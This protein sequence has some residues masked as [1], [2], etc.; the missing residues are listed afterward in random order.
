MGR[1]HFS[2]FFL[3]KRNA[4]RSKVDT[5][6]TTK[7]NE[8]N[9]AISSTLSRKDEADSAATVVMNQK[10]TIRSFKDSADNLF[11]TLQSLTTGSAAEAQRGLIESL[12]EQAAN[13]LKE[14]EEAR[15]VAE[16][17]ALDAAKFYEGTRSSTTALAYK[18]DADSARDAAIEAVKEAKE[19]KA[20]ID[21]KL[22]LAVEETSDIK[23][24]EFKS[25]AGVSIP[26]RSADP[27]SAAE[28]TLYY[29]TGDDKLY[30]KTGDG[31]GSVGGGPSLGNNS[32][33]RTNS[34]N[35]QSNIT[36]DSNTNAMSVGPITVDSGYT[37]TVNG[38]WNVV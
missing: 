29:H 20:E 36:V 32:I 30:L 7:T 1:R 5:Y 14:A 23:L 24:A 19:L 31:F 17:K 6:V 12:A 28:G 11:T 13:A 10:A 21:R 35:I 4:L 34:K 18:N 16:S 22:T 9:T 2:S 8:R 3:T 37:V 33:I 15:L 25:D 38:R 27:S 26:H